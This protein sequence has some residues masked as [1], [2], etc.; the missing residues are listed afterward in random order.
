MIMDLN[1]NDLL[2]ESSQ[3]ELSHLNLQSQS[4]CYL[5]A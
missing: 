4:K 5:G 3:E 2:Q 1:E